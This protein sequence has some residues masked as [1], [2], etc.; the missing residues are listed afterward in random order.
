MT[1]QNIVLVPSMCSPQPP[2]SFYTKLKISGKTGYPYFFSSVGIRHIYMPDDCRD[3]GGSL[4]D[5]QMSRQYSVLQSHAMPQSIK[6]SMPI[7]IG[8]NTNLRRWKHINARLFN[9][10]LHA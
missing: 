8:E 5:V 2:S 3:I 9:S 1:E 6:W 7:K 4:S 10:E